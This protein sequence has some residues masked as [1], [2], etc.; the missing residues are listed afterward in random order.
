MTDPD[1]L[2]IRELA[3]MPI[4]PNDQSSQQQIWEIYKPILCHFYWIY[5]LRS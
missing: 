4:S 2:E 3:E 1:E 5:A